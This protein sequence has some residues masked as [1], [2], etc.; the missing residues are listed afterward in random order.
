MRSRFTYRCSDKE[1]IQTPPGCGYTNMLQKRFHKHIFPGIYLQI[2]PDYI[3]MDLLEEVDREI[4][5][6]K[7]RDF[8]SFLA[9]IAL[10]FIKISAFVL[11][12]DS[13]LT[14]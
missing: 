8:T 1:F 12:L 11:C 9:P 3:L 6:E 13:N 14:A 10:P 4:I 7:I 2:V 5:F